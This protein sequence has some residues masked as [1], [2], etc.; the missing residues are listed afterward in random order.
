M[1]TLV[2][3]KKIQTLVSKIPQRD[4]PLHTVDYKPLFK[5]QLAR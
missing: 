3:A 5:S 4:P 1:K 2:Q